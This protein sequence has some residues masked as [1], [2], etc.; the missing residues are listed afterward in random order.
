[1]AKDE[2][3]ELNRRDFIRRAAATTAAAVWAAPIVQT[4]AATPA[5]AQ[6]QGSPAP[7]GGCFK[8]A[9]PAAGKLSGCIDTCHGAGCAQPN[10]ECASICYGACSLPEEACPDEF[11][12]SSCWACDDAGKQLFVC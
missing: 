6:S 5:Y 7:G 11:C 10:E 2:R 1:M 8:K 9:D 12:D 4:V 3:S